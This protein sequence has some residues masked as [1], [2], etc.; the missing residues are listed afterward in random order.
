MTVDPAIVRLAQPE[1][2]EALLALCRLDHAET[3]LRDVSGEPFPFSEERTRALLQRA[4]VRN[5][6]D[7]DGATAVCGVIGTPQGV[8]ATIYLTEVAPLYCD[9]TILRQVFSI[10]APAHRKSNH[11]RCLT[12]WSKIIAACL[13]KTLV[14]EVSAQRIEAKERFYARNYGGERIGSFYAFDPTP[15][16]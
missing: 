1:D 2:E 9:R 15:G 12:A 16:A 10:V 8:E 5:R 14:A 4:F 13:E 3:A 6:N 11:A 7:V